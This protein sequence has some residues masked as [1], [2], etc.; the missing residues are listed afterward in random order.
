VLFIAI[1]IA[2]TDVAARCR[3]RLVSIANGSKR[4]TSR[5]HRR[6]NRR[7]LQS[8]YYSRASSIR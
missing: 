1:A 2:L 6:P 7:R 8:N 3:T 5:R 4:R